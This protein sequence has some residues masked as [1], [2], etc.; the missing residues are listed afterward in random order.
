MI[1]SVRVASQRGRSL[2]LD[3]DKSNV[4]H[5]TIDRHNTWPNRPVVV[6]RS[7]RQSHRPEVVGGMLLVAWHDSSMHD[8]TRYTFVLVE[9]ECSSCY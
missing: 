3:F 1:Q 6:L 7:V 5:E 4:P 8:N 2:H 9:E